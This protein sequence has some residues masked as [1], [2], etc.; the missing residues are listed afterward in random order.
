M[1]GPPALLLRTPR[2]IPLSDA[3]DALPDV[4]SLHIAGATDAASEAS[5]FTDRWMPGGLLD[6]DEVGQAHGALNPEAAAFVPRSHMPQVAEKTSNQSV[7][8]GTR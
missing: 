3:V 2:V 1:S 4:G 8:H 7:R 6:E 5:W